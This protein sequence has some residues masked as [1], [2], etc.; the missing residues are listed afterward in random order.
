MDKEALYQ[1]RLKRYTI[2]MRNGKPDRIPIR[3]FAAE[4]AAKYA[5][6]NCQQV[7]HD[8]VKAFEAICAC[9]RD[10]DWDATVA[11]MVYVWTGLTQAIGLKYY[12]IP[13]LHIPEDTGFQY[14]EPSEGQE[15]MRADEYDRLI[16][17]PTA[18]LYE[19]WLPRVSDRIRPAGQPADYRHN[20]ALVKGSMSMLQYFYAFGPQVARMRSEFGMVS[21]IAGIFK[22]PFDIL[23]DKLR[24]YIGLTMDMVEQPKKVLAA[25]EALM[26]HL[27]YVAQTTADAERNVPIGYWMHRGCVPFIRRSWFETHY[28][29]TVKPI[30]QELW[31]QGKQTLFYAEGNWNAHL[32][33]FLELPEGSIV[34]HVDQADLFEVHRRIGH[35]FCLSGGIP[36]YLLSYC[37]PQEV[38]EYCRKIIDEVAREGG[39]IADAAAIMQNDTSIENIRAMTEFIREYGVYSSSDSAPSGQK[40]ISKPNGSTAAVCQ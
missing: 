27:H 7:T 24:G 5:G 28:W 39:Y 12:G 35:K 14:R 33:R 2:A 22:A 21:A 32:D 17:D 31:A 6:F 38:R 23:A 36:N 20:L 34:F 8:Y 4:F 19:V 26:P 25:C 1:Q 13:G 15:F 16:E 18:F 10:F 9:A 29:P 37:S 40:T 11:N 30:V 3:P